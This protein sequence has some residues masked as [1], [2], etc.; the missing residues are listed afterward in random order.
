MRKSV[1]W[2]VV[3]FLGILAL[4]GV[5]ITTSHRPTSNT[6]D[7]QSR[8]EPEAGGAEAADADAEA[9][10]V[11]PEAGRPACPTD[12]LGGV[13]LP[14]LG[15]SVDTAT[16]ADGQVKAQSKQA[17]AARPSPAAASAALAKPQKRDG[18]I[19]V[20]LWAWWCAPCREELPLFDELARRH[21]EL[22]VMGVHA[23]A[24]AQRG[25]DLLESLESSLPSLQDNHN[26][27]AGTLGLPGVVPITVVFDAQGNMIANF[28]Q[29]MKSI[30]ELETAVAKAA[31][32]AQAGDTAAT[33]ERAGS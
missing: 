29:P 14:C 22:T 28:P 13:T 10:A 11:H 19:V 23:D 4:L 25:I 27:F 17:S 31:A 30:E 15:A 9:N 21:P 16:Q 12:T 20:N 7:S 8:Q 1:L 5:L 2:S 18:L 26:A 32:S 6:A 24:S 33:A 3:G